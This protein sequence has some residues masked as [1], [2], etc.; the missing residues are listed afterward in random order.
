M[1]LNSKSVRYRDLQ[2]LTLVIL[3]KDREAELNQTLNYWSKTPVSIVIIHDTQNPLKSN[4]LNTN[5]VYINSKEHILDR[6]LLSLSYILTPYAMIANDDEIF[7]YDPLVKFINFLDD[8]SNFEAVGG[9]VI[10]Y[11][12][13]GNKLLSNQIYPFLKNFSN[14]EKLPINRIR[15]TFET[16]NVMDLTLMY[17]SE[18]FKCIVKCC[19]YFSKYSTPVMYETM[20]AFFSSYFCR[21]FRM[22]D[23][24]WM[25]NWFTPFQQLEK[26]DRK[27]TWNAWCT[28]PKF[29]VEVADW[30]NVF[31]AVVKNELNFSNLEIESF[32]KYLINWAAIGNNKKFSR[33][34]VKWAFLKN[35]IRPFLPDFLVWKLKRIF[36]F[37]RRK[38][39]PDLGSLVNAK[40]SYLNISP[41]D[42]ENFKYFAIEQKMLLKK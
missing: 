33:N 40:N 25:R 1:K 6:L 28:D 39:M 14:S 41:S 5:V 27:L 9:P 16:K 7:L 23:I 31:A 17:R 13:F 37:F 35:Y 8:E 18:Q 36:P 2:K 42:L 15:T 4:A 34:E 19:S 30:E 21:S 32:I 24:Y 12:W 11:T 29:Q 20:F 22:D 26:W 10:S 38:I 3:S